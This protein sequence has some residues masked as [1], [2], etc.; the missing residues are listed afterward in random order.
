MSAPRL[1]SLNV[2]LLVPLRAA[3]EGLPALRHVLLMAGPQPGSDHTQQ[4]QQERRGVFSS[5]H[6]EAQWAAEAAQEPQRLTAAQTAAVLP[7]Y[8]LEAV[9]G[10]LQS[11]MDR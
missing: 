10:M 11:C 3:W 6:L 8:A 1:L 5:Q 7:Q 4:Q 9:A 2:P